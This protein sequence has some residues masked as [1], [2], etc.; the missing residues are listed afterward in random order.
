VGLFPPNGYGLY[1]MAGNAT[2]CC[3]DYYVPSSDAAIGSPYLGGTDPCGPNWDGGLGRVLRG[4]DG[5]LIASFARCAGRFSDADFSQNDIF[6][7]FGRCV[8]GPS[9]FGEA[10]FDNFSTGLNAT[11]WSVSQTTANL[12]SVN[13][14]QG[15]IHLAKAAHNPGGTQNV[16]VH[17]NL[18]QLGGA[19]TND[20][21]VQID[22]TNAVVGTGLDQVELR[23]YYQDGSFFVAGYEYSSGLKAYGSWNGTTLF[24]ISVTGNCGTFRIC[25]TGSEINGIF[26]G[27]ALW[28]S[29]ST[30]SCLTN[31][32][33]VLQNAS[34]SDDASSVTFE[35]FSLT[36]ASLPAR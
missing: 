15:Q 17:L 28:D 8:V 5:Y 35:N 33:F 2:E 27:Q 20:F 18:A 29:G 32:T 7:G 25:R 13:A 23:T 11:D 16:S 19:I 30:T 6:L 22:F 12:Y 3:W 21:S 10:F 26:N 36:S 24:P 9:A 34:G 1:D 31:V 4:G 14:S